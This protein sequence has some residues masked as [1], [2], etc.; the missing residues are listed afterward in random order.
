MTVE[1]T[2]T[3]HFDDE[4]AKMLDLVREETSNIFTESEVVIHCIDSYLIHRI[5]HEY[6]QARIRSLQDKNQKLRMDVE[7]A[8]EVNLNFLGQSANREDFY[9]SIG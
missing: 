5:Y 7:D 2:L 3:L 1:K 8:R 9:G 6:L 4:Q